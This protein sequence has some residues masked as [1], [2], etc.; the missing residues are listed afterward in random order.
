MNGAFPTRLAV[1]A[2][3]SL[4]ACVTEAHGRY[5][6]AQLADT[7]TAPDGNAGLVL[8]EFALQSPGVVDGDTLKVVGLEGSLRLLGLDAEETFKS[9]KDLRA[10]EGGFDAYTAKKQAGHDRPVKFATPLGM[11]AKHWAEGFLEGVRTVRVE[12]DH[13]KELRDRYDRLLAYVMVEKDGRW[14]NFN[15]ECVRAGMSPYFSKYGYSR[16]FHE[17]FV[18]A[19]AQAQ[20]AE[21]GIWDPAGEHYRDYDVRLRWWNA[22]AEVVARFDEKAEGRDNWIALTHWDAMARLEALEGREVV[23]LATVGDVRP[24]EGKRPARVMLS[25]KMFSD[26]PLIFFDDDVLALS[27]VE[28]ARSEYVR[29]QGTVSRYVFRTK[30]AALRKE[31]EPRSQLQIQIRRPEQI[32]FVDT[33]P[34][35]IAAGDVLPASGPPTELT[36][37]PTEPEP[38]EPEPLEPTPTEPMPTE[39][40]PTVPVPTVPV[41]T[42]PPPTPT[43]SQGSP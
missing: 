30:R 28:D 26:L 23:V 8:G 10:Y 15:V 1:M 42:V 27:H 29:V 3:L 16:R 13:P 24:R 40:V 12:R 6:R 36:E 22:R 14:L 35:A 43:H 4:T 20:A 31:Q 17:E 2:L 21:R 32:A 5:D 34:G 19:Q 25:R 41:P 18:E 11:E 7:L 9:E 38:T 39:P 33:R 37:P